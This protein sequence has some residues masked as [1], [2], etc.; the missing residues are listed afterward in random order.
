MANT[1]FNVLYL[2]ID[3]KYGYIVEKNRKLCLNFKDKIVGF[4]DINLWTICLDSLSSE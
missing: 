1:L 3:I 2:Y 4:K